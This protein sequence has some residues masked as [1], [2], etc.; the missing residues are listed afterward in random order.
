MNSRLR[1]VTWLAVLLLAGGGGYGYLRYGAAHRKQEIKYET[2]KVDVGSVISKITATGTLSALVTVQ[3]GSQVSGRLQQIMVDFNSKVKKGEV[4]AKLDPQLFRAALE[5]GK[6]NAAVARANLARSQ[7][8][9]LDAE[10]QYQRAKSLVEQKLISQADADTAQATSGA[11]KAQVEASQAEVEQAAASLHQAQVNL[12]YTTIVSPINGVVISRNVDVG[13]TVAAS[14]QAPTLFVIAEDLGKMQ[15][16]ASVAEADV[17]KLQ[18]G[19]T[20]NFSVDAYPGERFRGTIRQIRNA[21]QTLQ[22]VVTYDAVIDV[23]NRDLK[24][25]PGMTASVTFVHAERDNV[26]RIPNAALRFRPAPDVVARLRGEIPKRGA[27]QAATPAASAVPVGKHVKGAN[28]EDPTKRVVWALAGAKPKSVPIRIGVTD[29]T[30]TELVE[31][32]LNAGDTLITDVPELPGA[33]GGQG[34]SPF[35][36]F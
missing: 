17:G 30:M 28:F 35:R 10:R 22:N 21:P 13:Q 29:G 3:V 7:V 34:R 32:S 12:D 33:K 36:M 8:Q 23:D 1:N 31:G 18:P 25:K 5:Q 24:L 15:V 9:A 4:I 2:A 19:M 20:A 14:L 6:A 11:A 27:E 26:L 16:D